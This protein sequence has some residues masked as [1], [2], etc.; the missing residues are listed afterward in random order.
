MEIAEWNTDRLL[1]EQ[2]MRIFFM[3][4]YY[5]ISK[6]INPYGC[7]DFDQDN[8]KEYNTLMSCK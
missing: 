7:K 1:L 3:E 5:A 6:Q 8:D 2:Q 4:F